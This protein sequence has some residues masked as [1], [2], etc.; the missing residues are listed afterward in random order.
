[1][2]KRQNVGFVWVK[3]LTKPDYILAILSGVSAYVMQMVTVPKD[4]MQGPMKMCIRDRV[5]LKESMVV[6]ILDE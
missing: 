5:K 1:M 6:E 3:S 4:Q 2:Y